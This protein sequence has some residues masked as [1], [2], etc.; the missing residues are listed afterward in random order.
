MAPAAKTAP[1]TRIDPTF[2]WVGMKNPKLQLLVPGET[3]APGTL[4]RTDSLQ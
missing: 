1:L 3:A 2:W 4:T